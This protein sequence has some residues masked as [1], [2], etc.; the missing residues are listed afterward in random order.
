MKFR[1]FTTIA[2]SS[3]IG[4][5]LLTAACGGDTAEDDSEIRPGVGAS[6][7]RYSSAE[8]S[9]AAPESERG[10]SIVSQ[11]GGSPGTVA[12]DDQQSIPF[13]RKIIFT[14]AI[15]LSVP[16][17]TS[18]FTEVQRIAR[19]AGGYVEAS[20]LSV[21]AASDDD[22]AQR[23][24]VTLRVPADEYDNVLNSLRVL[25][26]SKVTR[27]QAQSNEVTEQYVDLQSRLRNLERSEEQYLTLLAKAASI[28]DIITVNDRLDGIRAEIEQIQG[29]LNVLD[30]MTDMATIDVSLTPLA[31]ARVEETKS[32]G[33][34]TPAEA[35]SAALEVSADALRV[36]A[37][38]G[39]VAVVALGWLIPVG[40]FALIIRR[41]AKNRRVGHPA[42]ETPV[43]PSI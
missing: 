41:L 17:V 21:L 28:D 9:S 8:D 4:L 15:D 30:H 39:A 12:S 38:A 3:F 34:S 35:F 10:N 13:D 19:S 23:A 24:S 11:P 14:T 27:E 7:E 29:R 32:G 6:G 42:P 37:A 16:D 36:L 43:T 2:T 1:R 18:S 25:N 33:I 40:V 26:G 22:G 20:N 31:A 5:A